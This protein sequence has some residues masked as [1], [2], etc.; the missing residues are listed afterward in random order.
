[1]GLL[2]DKVVLITGATGG[3][4]RAAAMALANEG[5]ELF[6]LCRNR[7]RGEATRRAIQAETGNDRTSLLL[8]DLSSQ[9]EIRRAADEFLSLD[10]PLHVLLNNAGVLNFWREDTVDGIEGTWAV[11]HLAYFL[12]TVLLLE[13]LK[14]SAPAR[15]VS[16]SSDAHA[17]AKDRLDFDDLGGRNIA[18]AMTRYGISKCANILFT[19][20]LA[21]R[22]EGTGVTANCFHPGFVGTG[23]ATNNGFV[24]AIAMRLLS[25]FNRTPEEGADTGVFLCSDPAVEGQSGLY[26]EDREARWP[27]RFAQNDEDAARL[28]VESER[29]VGISS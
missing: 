4:G 13:R 6:L 21:R 27:K 9:A 25:A 18:N 3:I 15:I 10:K 2:D 26:F 29:Q 14:E 20:E 17:W 19:R 5:P 1:M 7:E 28:W 22:L 16:V 23:F 12:L 8:C 11:N 24:S